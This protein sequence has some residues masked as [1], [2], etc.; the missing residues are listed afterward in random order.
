MLHFYN[1][2]IVFISMFSAF[3][4]AHVASKGRFFKFLLSREGR[5]GAIDG[6]RGYLALA[7]FCHHF[8]MTWNYH[9]NGSWSLPQAYMKGYF[10]NLGKVGVALFFMITGF[11]FVSKLIKKNMR[12]DWFSLYKSRVY[13]IVPLYLFALVII[14]LVVVIYSEFQLNVSLAELSWQYVK[15]VLFNGGVINDFSETKLVIAGVDWSLKYEWVFYL[16]LPIVGWVL[17]YFAKYRGL[18]LVLVNVALLLLIYRHVSLLSINTAYFILFTAGGLAAHINEK[19]KIDKA[20]VNSKLMSC[21]A[22]VLLIATVLYPNSFDRVHYVMLFLFFLMVVMGNNLFGVFTNKASV[23]LGEVSYSI[24][25]L[26]GFVLYLIFTILGISAI[27]YKFQLYLLLMPI[28]SVVV[29]GVSMATYLYIEKPFIQLNSRPKKTQ[30]T[31]NDGSLPVLGVV[32][33]N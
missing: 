25:L 15:W 20:V 8:V 32:D 9:N 22:L 4:F 31:S 26:H 1:L 6:L 30:K 33:G 13:R 7:V 18:L 24:Y 21:F 27:E 28:I 3:C 29:V 17:A 16:S 12:L 11:L 5:Y 23:L 19:Y 10:L 14:S 2:G